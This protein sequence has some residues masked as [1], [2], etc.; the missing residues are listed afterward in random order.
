MIWINEMVILILAAL[1]W[2]IPNISRPTIRLGVSVPRERIHDP[3]VRTAI[4]RYR[5][6]G[7][8]GTTVILLVVILFVSSTLAG[9][10]GILATVLLW[11]A[12]LV[13]CRRPIMRAKREQGWYTGKIVRLSAPV[14]GAPSRF[15]PFVIFHALA[16][17]LI[18]ASG[19]ATAAHYA[20]LPD[21]YPIHWGIAGNADGWAPKSW[22]TVLS[23]PIVALVLALLIAVATWFMAS[24]RETFLPDGNA[25]DSRQRNKS[26][27]RVMNITMAVLNV[28]FAITMSVATVT[29]L[30]NARWLG[31]LTIISTSTLV[32][33][34]AT[35]IACTIAAVR[36]ESADRASRTDSA[37]SPDDDAVWKLGL[38][39]VNRD[40]PSV[41]VPKRNGFGMTFNFGSPW[42]ML[43]MIGLVALPIVAIA[44]PLAFH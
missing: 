10:L 7:T 44:L 14:T 5:M 2:L 25:H 27:R 41:M 38:F 36:I 8:I 17:S 40:D 34:V 13:V 3:A 39:Y 23:T 24:K 4:T 1:M 32:A 9:F 42:G 21:R 28:C 43:I 16:V 33:T 11:T 22:I 29:P 19:V 18:I 6:A 31:T 26:M 35:L 37:E 30:A 20:Q 15:S 12:T